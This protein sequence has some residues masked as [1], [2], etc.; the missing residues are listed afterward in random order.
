[1]RIIWVSHSAW[2]GGGA[3]L[4]MLEGVKG[5]KAEGHSIQVVS[6]SEGNLVEWLTAMGVPT[7]ICNPSYG[8]W[9]YLNFVP[10]YHYR[11]RR[12]TQNIRAARKIAEFIQQFKPDVVVTNTI[13]SPA[14]AFAARWANVPHIWYVHEMF[15]MDCHDQVLFDLG[16]KLSLSIMNK[17]SSRIIVN[18]KIVRGLFSRGISQEKLRLV[19]YAMDAPQKVAD[20]QSDHELKLIIVGRVTPGKRQEDAIRAVRS[21]ADRKIDVHLSVVGNAQQKYGEFLQNLTRQLG[22][23]EQVSFIPF[24]DDPH[25]HVARSDI[26][27]MCSR[28]EPFGR[29]TVEAM[30]QGVPVVGAASGGT[31]E[32]IRDGVTGFLYQL[33]DPNDLSTKIEIL[34]RNRQLLGRMSATARQWANSSFSLKKYTSDLLAVFEETIANTKS[35]SRH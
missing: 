9:A 2:I 5:L 20:K 35:G 16:E 19:Y 13:G 17:L 18:S 4:A 33:G 3:E 15:G 8:E 22:L 11:V 6:P 23:E 32:I 31:T 30:K 14:G 1:M 21:L 29:V 24:T 28:G 10:R 34:H 25:S 7:L 12:M 26:A 27:L